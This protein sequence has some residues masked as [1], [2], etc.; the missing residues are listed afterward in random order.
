MRALSRL[1]EERR[2]LVADKNRISNRL[3]DALKQY[4]PA[5]LDWFE[6]KDTL[7]FRDFLTP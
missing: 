1:V 5:V 2:R 4:F 7:L 3:T 6:D